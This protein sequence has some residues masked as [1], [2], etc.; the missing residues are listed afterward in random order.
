MKIFEILSGAIVLAIA[1]GF[2]YF[3]YQ[4]GYAPIQSG[5]TLYVSF[6]QLNGVQCGQDVKIGGI[7]IGEVRGKSIDPETYQGKA[8]LWIDKDIMLPKDSSAEIASESL[9]G[10]RFIQLNPGKDKV[11]LPEKSI[12]YNT[13]SPTT[14]ESVVKNFLL[15]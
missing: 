6:D 2:S 13:A 10:G 3:S 9:L 11:M 15:G 12:I 1:S 7:K 8:E 5:Y 14:L 4:N